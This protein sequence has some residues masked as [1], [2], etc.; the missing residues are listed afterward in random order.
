MHIHPPTVGLGSP[1]PVLHHTISLDF[2]LVY[3][4]R[5]ILSGYDLSR[6]LLSV[7]FILFGIF[8]PRIY[9]VQYILSGY[10]LFEYILSGFSLSINL[11][12]SHY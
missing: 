7:I 2:C 3:F 10:S 12:S 9:L 8:C 6:Y 1:D 11:L 5:Y 4:V